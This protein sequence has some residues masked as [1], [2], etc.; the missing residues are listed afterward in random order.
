MSWLNYLKEEQPELPKKEE[1]KKEQVENN[2]VHNR[3]MEVSMI[4]KDEKNMTGTAEDINAFLG[5]GTEFKGII[6][7]DGTIKVDGKIEGEIITKG[8]LIV[9]ETA[10]IDAQISAGIIICAG[11]ITGNITANKK[12]QLQAPAVLNGSIKS[13]QVVIDEGVIF[14]GNCEMKPEGA[15]SI[16]PKEFKENQPPTLSKSTA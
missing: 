13:P 11:K 3:N 4:K 2:N 15:S 14:N 6:S 5:Q 16:K 10:Q 9:G 8:T 7:Y 12:V 1:P